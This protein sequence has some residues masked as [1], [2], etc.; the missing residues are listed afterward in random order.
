MRFSVLLRGAC[1]LLLGAAPAGCDGDPGPGEVPTQW[2]FGGERPVTLQFPDRYD[3]AVPTPLLILLHG[4]TANGLVQTAYTGL[5]NLVEE[6]GI[7]FAAP[8]G[9][10]GPDG[11]SF[12]NATNA[13]CDY[14]GT[15][16]DDVGYLGGLIEEISSVWNVDPARVFLV[17]HSNGGFMSYRM[18]CERADLIAAVVSLAGATWQDH[19]ACAPARPVSVLQIHGDLDES[20]RYEGGQYYPSAPGTVERWAGENGCSGALAAVSERLD[21]DRSV[22]GDETRIERHGGCDGQAAAELWTIEGGGH[23]PGLTATF[24]AAVWD[25][26]DAHPGSP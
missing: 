19:A 10:V 16:V 25:W 18:A 5:G 3:H 6:Q 26:L 24:R 21:L 20:I 2:Q 12:W 4:Y 14:H 23:L 11:K 8:D 15:G 13:C 22:S 7:L 9:T 1:A 17:G